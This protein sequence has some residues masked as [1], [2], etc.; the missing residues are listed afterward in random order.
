MRSLATARI[1]IREEGSRARAGSVVVLV[2]W[3]LFFLV[4]LAV[5]VG[6]HVAANLRVTEKVRNRVKAYCLARAGIER[7]VFEAMS[8]T[9][10]W[11]SVK[12]PWRNDEEIFK[13]VKLGDGTYSVSYTS[14]TPS[15]VVTNHGVI[16]E[17]S[18]INFNKAGASLLKTAFETIGGLDSMLASDA[19]AAIIDWRDQNDDVLTGGAE[20]SYY[21]SLTEPYKCHNAD[22]QSLHELLLVKGIG[23]AVFERIRPYITIFGDGKVN[24][25]TAEPVVVACM[26]EAAGGADRAACRS[27]ADKISRFRAAGNVFTEAGGMINRLNAFMELSVSEK[28]AFARIMNGITIKSACLAGTASGRVAGATADERQIEFVFDRR[29]GVKL[30]WHEF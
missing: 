8:D 9:N 25:N 23:K 16:D 10:A 27:L 30:Y 1:F 13:N 22:L 6:A 18:R 21:A 2:S 4:S 3:A 14:V 12:E 15:G 5:A 24:I 26:A 29:Q 28:A 20:N 17:D 7:A 19:A 11:D